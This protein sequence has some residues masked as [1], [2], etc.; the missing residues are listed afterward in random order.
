[1]AARAPTRD[2]NVG[3]DP[4]AVDAS[5]GCPERGTNLSSLPVRKV[6]VAP[7]QVAKVA[8]QQVSSRNQPNY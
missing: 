6:A 3:M 7:D 2:F 4:Q 5:T 8:A 1:M